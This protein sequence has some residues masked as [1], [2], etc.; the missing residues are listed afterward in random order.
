MSSA[1]PGGAAVGAVASLSLGNSGG[2]STTAWALVGAA[3]TVAAVLSIAGIKNVTRLILIGFAVALFTQAVVS[4]L[5]LTADIR[6]AATSQVW[7]SGSTGLVRSPDLPRLILGVIPFLLLGLIGAHNLPILSHDDATIAGLGVRA[8]AERAR[9]IIAATGC[10]G[11]V[12]SIVGPIGFIA[13]IAPHLA[14]IATRAPLASPLVSTA[15]GAALMGLC[16]V[17][18]EFLPFT[19][20]VGII[21]L[22][23]GGTPSSSSSST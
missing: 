9:F 2:A 7:L 4:Y 3:V 6:D 17:A 8:G 5:I 10:V 16:E 20:P 23:I 21:T 15:A 18:A 1:Y 12:V 14:R 19:V 11:V 13:L 22:A